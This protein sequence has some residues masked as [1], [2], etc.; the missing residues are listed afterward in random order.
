[1]T[2][3]I[4]FVITKEVWDEV[5][6]F[7]EGF[8][9]GYMEDNDYHHRVNLLGIPTTYPQLD[10]DHFTSSTINTNKDIADAVSFLV[11]HRESRYM[12]KWGGMPGNEIYSTPWNGGEPTT[13]LKQLY[14]EQHGL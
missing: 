14:K 11:P 9:P 5:G 6:E 8:W 7:D 3:F 12:A 4:T 13:P 1:M 2:G 10:F